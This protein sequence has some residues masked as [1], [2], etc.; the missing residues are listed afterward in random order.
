MLIINWTAAAAG[1]AI[2]TK[3]HQNSFVLDEE[4]NKIIIFQAS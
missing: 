2:K 3:I 4:L 1:M